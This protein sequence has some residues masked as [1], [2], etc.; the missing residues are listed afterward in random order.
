MGIATES[1]KKNPEVTTNDEV[2]EILVDQNSSEIADKKPATNEKNV[3][4]DKID[5]KEVT[6]DIVDK[7]EVP[8]VTIDEKE[9]PEVT[10]DKKEV[11]EVTTDEKG[12]SET[13]SAKKDTSEITI[14]EEEASEIT[15]DDN[16]ASEITIDEKEIASDEKEV[17]EISNNEN[18]E[19]RKDVPETSMKTK[20]VEQVSEIFDKNSSNIRRVARKST[21]PP[22]DP[23][24]DSNKFLDDEIIVEEVYNEK[25]ELYDKQALDGKSTEDKEE[26]DI[27]DFLEVTIE[28]ES[29]VEQLSKPLDEDKNTEE[30]EIKTMVIENKSENRSEEVITLEDDTSV[31]ENCKK[32]ET[33]YSEEQKKI[34]EVNLEEVLLLASPTRSSGCSLEEISS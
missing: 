23:Q 25:K 12:T 13:T 4:E 14:E 10:L 8:E 24:K 3:P 34:E 16:E 26:I 11:P 29:N 1:A 31:S 17:L 5:Q 15:I 33:E 9:I 2:S 27:T 22:R 21:R 30:K 20:V 32:I 6:E 28:D 19:G 7:K 18:K